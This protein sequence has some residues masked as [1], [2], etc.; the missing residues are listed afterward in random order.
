M[1]RHITLL[2]ALLALSIGLYAQAN[3]APVLSNTYE[4]GA[5]SVTLHWTP[6]TPPDGNDPLF[7]YQFY[8]G[9]QVF[10]DTYMY[11]PQGDMIPAF[12]EQT[13]V[14]S[15]TVTGLL[16]NLEIRLRMTAFYGDA[17]TN[18]ES[19]P[20]NHIQVTPSSGYPKPTGLSIE[21]HGGEGE[22]RLSWTKPVAIL[23]PV[24]GY[25]IYQRDI[26][27][28]YELEAIDFL[29][30]DTSDT[31]YYDITGL[32]L[33]DT[34]YYSVAALYGTYTLGQDGDLEDI[35]DAL[36]ETNPTLFLSDPANDVFITLP[37]P[38]PRPQGFSL[39]ALN[40]QTITLN[41]VVPDLS[42]MENPPVLFGYLLHRYTN[43]YAPYAFIWGYDEDSADP[44][45]PDLIYYFDYDIENLT[46]GET[47][48]FAL[49][50]LYGTFD[51][52]GGIVLADIVSAIG[53]DLQ[54]SNKT[55]N[56]SATPLDPASLPS[57]TG[58]TLLNYDSSG[59]YMIAYLKWN[60]PLFGSS[61]TPPLPLQSYNMYVNGQDWGSTTATEDEFITGH[62]SYLSFGTE[63][64]VYVTAA[65]GTSMYGPFI[66]SLPSTSITFTGEAPPDK[67]FALSYTMTGYSVN[68][69]WKEPWEYSGAN[70]QE[71]PENFLGYKVVRYTIDLAA[72]KAH[73]SAGWTNTI[74][75][76]NLSGI[77][78]IDLTS[79]TLAEAPFF[80]D[81]Q[82]ATNIAYIYGISAV[83]A[84]AGV[85]DPDVVTVPQRLLVTIKTEDAP[86]TET[87]TNSSSFTIFDE[88]VGSGNYSTFDGWYGFTGYLFDDDFEIGTG[89]LWTPAYS[90]ANDYTAGNA[91]GTRYIFNGWYASP[92]INVG[93]GN[94]VDV[95]FKLALT[96]SWD[97]TPPTLDDDDEYVFAV[98]VSTD[99]GTTWSQN[100]IR[101][102]WATDLSSFDTPTP[103]DFTTISHT[104]E[105]INLSLTDVSGD[106]R[107]AFFAC[108]SINPETAFDEWG[109]YTPDAKIF[110]DD[111]SVT[112]GTLPPPPP[113]PAPT[114]LEGVVT[115]N[116]VALSWNTPAANVDFTLA[117]SDEAYDYIGAD[118]PSLF[119]TY[120]MVHR[121]TEEMLDDMDLAG[122]DLTAVSFLASDDAITYT[123]KVWTGGSYT[124]GV[125]TP[126]TQAAS[127]AVVDPEEEDWTVVTLTTPITIPTTGEL[128]IGYS[129]ALSAMGYIAGCDDYDDADMNALGNVLCFE[130]AA[131]PGTTIWTTLSDLQ[132]QSQL[133]VWHCNW[134]IKG[135]V[136][137]TEAM[138]GFVP[139]AS[140][141][142]YRKA[143]ADA[144]YGSSIGNSTSLNY[145]DTVLISGTHEYNYVVKAV[146]TVGG[147]SEP[148]N[149]QTVTVTYTPPTYT[150]TGTVTF[151]ENDEEY[152]PTAAT[153]KLV[154]R[155][156]AGDDYGPATVNLTTHAFTDIT[157]VLAG[158]YDVIVTMTI[159][160][161]EQDTIFTHTTEAAPFVVSAENAP[162]TLTINVPDSAGDDDM[163]DVP[164]VT[165]LQSNYP[166]PFNPST[167]I[168]FDVAKAGRVSIEIYNIKG[169]RVK[170]LVND[171]YA[172]G[173]HNVVW[174]GD[175]T[176]G[177]KVGSG[178][179]FYR[180]T[181]GDY[182]SI[183][184][185]LLMK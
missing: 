114:G 159:A 49:S 105:T 167:T 46:Y 179:Y 62:L 152:M 42:S 9:I 174:N 29:Q 109:Y 119:G 106:I 118:D 108:S 135:T 151:A 112:I 57:P 158:S 147:E 103:L 121:Y 72:Y 148:S 44:N 163:T 143:S 54:T 113:T 35:L 176:S 138:P 30:D 65:Y 111:F 89:F 154:N 169:Q 6:P 5:L 63:Y 178:V 97:S 51:I 77:T 181:T 156:D 43:D 85:A 34:Y 59:S 150:V 13:P 61:D 26:A 74:N 52:S 101:K 92:T 88:T 12:D 32:V 132:A 170:T 102:I 84:G 162:H 82:I 180:M 93:D 86:Y 83:Y 87:F 110:I 2:V 71:E 79:T 75:N 37:A 66:E 173:K 172:A 142:V 15:H 80:T 146:Y 136:L 164:V 45:D 3:P 96:D 137:T 131:A 23:A 68:L 58:L 56:V 11:F 4:L 67:P 153:V 157:G 20:S 144:N 175:D 126:G 104:G 19:E 117:T 18:E 171:D 17:T 139:P 133:P 128:W 134:M 122:K 36:E 149:T 116:T 47:Y 69:S 21:A 166:N 81:S 155:D 130:P 38:Y 14:T 185:M 41:W 90:F 124:G 48:T 141:N 31:P 127:Q 16:D 25:I 99:N 8:S 165:A 107:I 129:G 160:I 177:R 78:P 91:I 70:T 64:T 98:L 76:F 1:K 168:A 94:Q 120:T 40:D 123:V 125:F 39:G 145:T 140:Y 24:W 53:T 7:G 22:A 95:S 28:T 33:E 73:L 50:T 60:N 184:K 183:K 27:D 182:N 100:H 55:S 10:G 115:D 161:Y